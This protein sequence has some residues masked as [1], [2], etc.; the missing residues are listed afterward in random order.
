MARNFEILLRPLLT[1]KSTMLQE[2]HNQYVFEIN[3][4]ANRLEVKK[5]IERIFPKVKVEEVRVVHVRGKYRR[6]GRNIGKRPNWK[7]AIVRLRKGDQ[8]EF[9]EG[10]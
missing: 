10:A 9:F 5:E 6:I 7:K 2:A 4:T 8:I 3:P 1:E